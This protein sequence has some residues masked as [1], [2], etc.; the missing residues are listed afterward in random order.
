VHNNLMAIWLRFAIIMYVQYITE[1]APYLYNPELEL[2][3]TIPVISVFYY[4]V[5]I[6]SNNKKFNQLLA[7]SFTAP[8]L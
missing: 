8:A 4:T 7:F 1:I 2:K 3:P 5:I 6:I